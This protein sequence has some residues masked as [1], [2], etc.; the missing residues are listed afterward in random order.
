MYTQQPLPPLAFS[1][2]RLFKMEA[3]KKERK[4]FK[5]RAFKALTLPLPPY[6]RA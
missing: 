6:S 4:E 3:A 2:T 1:S 5:G